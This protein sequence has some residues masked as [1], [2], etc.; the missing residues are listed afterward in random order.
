MVDPIANDPTGTAR[1]VIVEPGK[2]IR[3][4]ATPNIAPADMAEFAQRLFGQPLESDMQRLIKTVDN[5][6]KSLAAS[7]QRLLDVVLSGPA[8]APDAFDGAI[9]YLAD[10]AA[11]DDKPAPGTKPAA[12]AKLEDRIAR[13]ERLVEKVVGSTKPA[14]AT[15]TTTKPAADAKAK[16]ASPA[17]AKAV[18]DAD[19]NVRPRKKTVWF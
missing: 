14:D 10:D 11:S 16:P 18:A 12:S 3:S 15:G 13:I 7:N 6:I 17:D 9:A 5:A 1:A 19:A 8:A 2:S 4:S